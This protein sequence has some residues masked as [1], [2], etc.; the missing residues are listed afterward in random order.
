MFFDAGRVD[1]DGFSVESDGCQKWTFVATFGD[2]VDFRRDFRRT[3]GGLPADC[4]PSEGKLIISN[5]GRVN[6]VSF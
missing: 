3:F 1:P 2:Q 6:S 5:A 4:H